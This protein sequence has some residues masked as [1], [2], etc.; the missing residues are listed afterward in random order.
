MRV[1]FEGAVELV[2]RVDGKIFITSDHGDALGE[3]GYFY[4]GREYPELDC[5]VNIPWFE[6]SR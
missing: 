5:L 4:H 2:K 6:V 1:A 3:N